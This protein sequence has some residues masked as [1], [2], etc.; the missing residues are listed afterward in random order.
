MYFIFHIL[1]L[2]IYTTYSAL[3]R[4]IVSN[5]MNC[6]KYSYQIIDTKRKYILRINFIY[7]LRYVF[8]QRRYCVTREKSARENIILLYFIA[9]NRVHTHA[10]HIGTI[11]KF[12]VYT[13]Q[14]C[15]GRRY[16]DVR[17]RVQGTFTR[18]HA[19]QSARERTT[20][21]R[22]VRRAQEFPAAQNPDNGAD[23]MNRQDLF[24]AQESVRQPPSSSENCRR[25]VYTYIHITLHIR[26]LRLRLHRTP[27]VNY[28]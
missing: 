7:L 21:H 2:Y 4:L 3:T 20:S 14:R 15:V 27:R 9:Y 24:A 1:Y 6:F 23:P 16:C 25:I 17:Y 8:T 22:T 10:S 11:I 5:F 26:L 19:I 18:L 13:R 12:N 28:Q